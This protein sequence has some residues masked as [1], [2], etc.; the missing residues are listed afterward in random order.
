VRGLGARGRTVEE[1]AGNRRILATVL[2]PAG[3]SLDAAGASLIFSLEIQSRPGWRRAGLD[4]EVP[5]LTRVISAV[6]SR[7]AVF[8]HAY[9]Y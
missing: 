7:G 1:I 9:D 3:A 2:A 4:I 6:E 5:Q 8:E